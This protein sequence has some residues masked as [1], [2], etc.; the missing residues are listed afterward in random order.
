MTFDSIL[1]AGVD[2]SGG[3]STGLNAAAHAEVG[4]INLGVQNES[5]PYGRLYVPNAKDDFVSIQ[6]GNAIVQDQILK[7][8]PFGGTPISPSLGDALYLLKKHEYL[9]KKTPT[10]QG[11]PYA[12]CR[13]RN[14]LLITDGRPTLGEGTYNYKT[15]IKAAES[16]YKNKHKVYVV[17]FNL[18]AGVSTIVD[19]IAQAGGTT[20]AH[21]ASTAAQLSAALSS[22]LGK[23]TPGI[24]SRTSTVATN[25]TYSAT[26]L[27]YQLNTAYSSAVKSDIDIAGYAEVTTYRCTKDCKDVDSGGAGACE[28][29]SI[30][31]KLNSN[32]SRTLYVTLDGK[33]EKLEKT[34]TK[35]TPDVFAIP[36]VGTIPDLKPKN[37]SGINVSSGKTLNAAEESNRI[38]FKN[39]LIDFLHAKTGTRREKERLGGIWHSTP[40]LQ[41]NLSNVDIASTSFKQ[42]RVKLKTTNRPT[43]AYFTSHEGFVHAIHLSRPVSS[44][45]SGTT[46]L[47]ELWAIAPQN[48]LT[49]FQRLASKTEFLIDGP[50][51]LKDI[52]LLK[53]SAALTLSQE[54]ALWR[55][56]LVVPFRQGGRGMFA[57]DV[58]DPFNP[59]VRWEIDNKRHCWLDE[60]TGTT[61]CKSFADDDKHDYRN[62]GYTHGKPKIGTIFLKN[63]STL[64]NEE[65]AAVF[66][67]CGDGAAGEP[68]SGR[69]FMVSRL[70]NGDKIKEFKNG[71][72]P[73]SVFD[74]SRAEGNVQDAIDFDMV[75]NPAAY[76][77][78]LGTFVT[79]LFVGDEG[80]QLWRIDV[81]SPDADKWKMEFFF[82]VYNNDLVTA[83]LTSKLRSPLR[84]AP[85]MS[86]VPQRGSLV[87]IF[88][89][90]DLDYATD[91]SQKTVV[92]SVKEILGIDTSTGAITGRT[93]VE[94]NW[95]KE[96]ENGENLTSRPII[97]GRV[98]YFTSF[99]PDQNDACS[100]GV[101][102]IWGVDYLLSKGTNE[103]V[104]RF[105]KDGNPA[106][107]NDLVE[108]VEL[109]DSIPYG[110]NLIN[111]PACAENAGIGDA[112]S[113]G[114]AGLPPGSSK[115]S[116]LSSAKPGQLE[117]VVQTGSAGKT[118][119]AAKPAKG[120]TPQVKKFHQRLVKP[121]KQ[122]IGVGWGQIHRL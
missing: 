118:N 36:K 55:S 26:D 9:V 84:T 99:K 13:A 57:I 46:W 76:N 29:T 109:K 78:F 34:N 56:V 92:Y 104:A 1:G 80:G 41:T 87:L 43:M 91:L 50:A 27:Q 35:L 49:R 40:A 101:G 4:L 81:S 52:R 86:P 33:I 106:T 77:T 48:A 61:S 3:W 120:G 24:H 23:A 108:Y 103:T 10:N 102:R 39:D 100:G 112:V 107:A 65:V 93:T 90:G 88:G 73:Q 85:S 5:A 42:Y 15:S 68:N 19:Q 53:N 79:R 110:I 66:F 45:P 62:L 69:C 58:T 31:D 94:V 32:N 2:A 60:G 6:A 98:A 72:T 70:D 21:I 113:G 63:R 54:T 47:K 122:V 83:K 96:L 89:S 38:I 44:S 7:A 64:N 14:V 105:D 97:F 16:L 74:D 28:V 18:A 95:R 25:I 17:G 12:Q 119:T 11:D 111:R 117:L 20:A 114:G 30:Q 121:P 75:G 116:A 37:F 51:V 82:D 67:P 59:F 8:I 115:K 22:I 71:T